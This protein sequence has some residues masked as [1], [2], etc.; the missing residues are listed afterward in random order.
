VRYNR[1][2]SSL[3]WETVSSPKALN[4][5]DRPPLIVYPRRLEFSASQDSAPCIRLSS[6]TSQSRQYDSGRRKISLSLWN[7]V[8]TTRSTCFKYRNCTFYTY[9]SCMILVVNR[10]YFLKINIIKK[11]SVAYWWRSLCLVNNFGNRIIRWLFARP[12]L[13][14]R[15]KLQRV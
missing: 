4:F 7:L 12:V 6:V 5:E 1:N 11:F 10:D 13:Y 14:R 9:R 15:R 8:G 2:A 3:R